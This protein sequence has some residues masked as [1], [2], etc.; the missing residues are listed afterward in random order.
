MDFP[1]QFAYEP[2]VVNADKLRPENGVILAGMGGSALAPALFAICQP[3]FKMIVHRNYGLPSCPPEDLKKYTLIASSYS[4][5]TEETI[6]AFES[7]IKAGMPV[8]VIA[9]GG[10]LLELAKEKQ[11]PYVELPNAGIQPREAL[12]FSLKAFLKL[13]GDDGALAMIKGLA[14]ALKPET[15]KAQGEALAKRIKGKIPLVYSSEG[16]A[17]LGY[18]WKIRFNETSKTPA[19]ANYFPELNHNEMTGFEGAGE[20]LELAKKFHFLVIRDNEDDPRI[21]KRKTIFKDI[22]REKG[23]EVD[24][25]ELVGDNL[26]Q[27]VFGS[28]MLADWT[29][30]F[31]AKEYG[32][33]PEA[34]PLVEKFKKLL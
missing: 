32:S 15:F 19:F 30:Y 29:S 1:K 14:G 27:K 31:L 12:G 20:S 21:L 24:E 25:L 3:N 18:V 7:A 10:K 6:D 34:V 28:V 8:A 16:D 26:A 9:T 4:G 17:G 13:I 23:F 11:I 33:D 22:F 5:N 2:V